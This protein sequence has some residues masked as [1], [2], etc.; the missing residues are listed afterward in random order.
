MLLNYRMNVLWQ[1]CDVVQAHTNVNNKVSGLLLIR[2][3]FKAVEYVPDFYSE[4][5]DAVRWEVRI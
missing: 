2:S 4:D 1:K 3:A 5:V